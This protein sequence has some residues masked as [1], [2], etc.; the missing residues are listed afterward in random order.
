MKYTVKELIK[1]LKKF[2]EDLKIETELAMMWNYPDEMY[3]SQ[4]INDL[5]YI[6]TTQNHATDLCI[7]EG[8]WKKGNVSDVDG[9][10]EECFKER[11]NNKDIKKNNHE[12]EMCYIIDE[13][14]PKEDTVSTTLGRFPKDWVL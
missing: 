8:S 2:P 9:K 6:E 14:Y 11:K 7:F 12:S 13:W 10:F 4:R 1:E 5:E 3:D